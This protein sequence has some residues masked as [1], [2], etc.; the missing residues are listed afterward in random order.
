MIAATGLKIM[1][2]KSLEWQDL[3]AKFYKN[4][5]VHSKLTSG[6]HTDGQTDRLVTSKASFSFLKKTRLEIAGSK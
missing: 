3:T 2:L 5:K 1:T 6:G 4:I